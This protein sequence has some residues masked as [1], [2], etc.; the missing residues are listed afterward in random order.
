MRWGQEAILP[1]AAPLEACTDQGLS[2]LLPL[3][4]PLRGTA[5]SS[6]L[7]KELAARWS[8]ARSKSSPQGP[9]HRRGLGCH[10]L[11]CVTHSC[12]AGAGM[13][14][15][16]GLRGIG[17][18]QCLTL[19][20]AALDFLLLL[21][22]TYDSPRQELVPERSPFLQ[23][24]EDTPCKCK[25]QTPSQGAHAT[26]PWLTAPAKAPK[27]IPA[28]VPHTAPGLTGSSKGTSKPTKP[29]VMS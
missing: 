4:C 17:K 21:S 9:G 5:Q 7:G 26:Y 25:T 10:S 23:A 2:L 28:H 15:G 12:P 3:Y 18:R 11:G 29:S 1:G 27:F 6:S 13:A 16:L 24:E 8:S 19:E 20:P 14:G 22:S